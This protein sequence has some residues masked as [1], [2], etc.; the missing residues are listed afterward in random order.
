M[1]AKPNLGKTLADITT[2]AR[3]ETQA[4]ARATHALPVFEGRRSCRHSRWSAERL[5]AASRTYLER[6]SDFTS[7]QRFVQFAGFPRSGHS[8]VGSILDAHPEAMIAH[9]LDAMGL[10]DLGLERDE[11]FALACSNSQE[12]EKNGRFWNGFSYAVPGGMG[13]RAEPLRVLGD[14]KGDWAVRHTLENPGLVKRLDSLLA[15]VE[16]SWIFVIRNPFD[17]IATLSL[18]KG[19]EYDRL[20]IASSGERDFR[21]ALSEQKGQSVTASV[22]PEMVEDYAR[23]CAGIAALKS[24]IPPNSW[25][26]LRHEDFVTAP[27]DRIAALCRFTGLETKEEFNEA[28]ASIVSSRPNPSRHEVSWGPGLQ[29]RVEGLIAQYDFLAG[30]AFDE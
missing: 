10:V 6:H 5:R 28:A 8:I 2:P 30:Y 19:R 12:F 16:Q 11:V 24:Q 25:F 21:Q 18:R 7:V 27:R 29:A 15:G 26:E 14:K 9:E 23:L 3:G 4:S 20:R 17:N 22:L 13:G 1:P